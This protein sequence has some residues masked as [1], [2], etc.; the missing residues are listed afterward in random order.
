VEQ[1]IEWATNGDKE[2]FNGACRTH[3]RACVRPCVRACVRLCP[4]T[5]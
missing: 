4:H 5:M 2:E 3:L 1:L